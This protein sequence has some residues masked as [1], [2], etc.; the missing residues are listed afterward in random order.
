MQQASGDLDREPP[1]DVAHRR[2]QREAPLIVLDGLERHGGQPDLAQAAREI[3]QRREMQIAEQQVILAQQLQVGVDRLFDLDDHLRLAEHLARRAQDADAD[4]AVMLIGI[5]TFFSGAGLHIDLMAIAHQLGTSRRNETH[6][7]LAR[8]QLARNTDSHVVLLENLSDSRFAMPGD[9]LTIAASGA[10][11]ASPPGAE[12]AA[13][14][15]WTVSGRP[16][17]AFGWEKLRAN[18]T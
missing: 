10:R 8:L 2:E 3:R 5:A 15:I 4:V 6:A 1:G 13:N 9:S 16:R 17:V 14:G 12:L 7:T 18:Y 11:R